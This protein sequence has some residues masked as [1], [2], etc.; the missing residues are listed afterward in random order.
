M[1]PR[2]AIASLQLLVAVAK[3]D[4][5]I[6]TSEREALED[7]L[8]DLTLPVDYSIDKLLS[9]E[10]VL[11]AVINEVKSTEA[12]KA[13]FKSAYLL[14]H[15]D[16]HFAKEEQHLLSMLQQR[17]NISNEEVTELN[18]SVNV[19]NAT[20]TSNVTTV[21]ASE[22]DV[23]VQKTIR[24]YLILTSLA[25]AIPIPLIG[26][27]MVIPLQMKMM[28]DLGKIYGFNLDKTTVKAMLGSLG[29]GTG[30]RIAVSSLAKFVPGW[31]SVVGATAAFST[32][33][34][35][36]N[37][38]TQYFESGGN[39]SIDSFKKAFQEK[40]EEGKKEYEKSR[41]QIEANKEVAKQLE[42]LGKALK[43]GK[44]TQGQY[45]QQVNKINSSL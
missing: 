6:E 29:V 13:A 26:D 21:N 8:K 1:Q 15:A 7:S 3:A 14:A 28:M 19:A 44:I 30:A 41:N 12:Q 25:G 38:A 34:A 35:L 39:L 36:G 32:T 40:K 24:N 23:T 18:N 2:E 27:L 9:Q 17:W 4:G 43:T 33:Y 11:E 45:D 31:G 22:R 16:G 5:K 37:V 10:V 20:V 42:D